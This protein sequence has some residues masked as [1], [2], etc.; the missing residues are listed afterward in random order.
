M[1]DDIFADRVAK[2]RQRFVSSL[3]EKIETTYAAIP[4]LGGT[5]PTAVAAAAEAYRCIHGIVG[6]GRTVGF[7]DIGTAA[8]NVE[9]VL[10][11]SYH[12]Q[13]G[14]TDDEISH[15]KTSLQ[16]LREVATRELQSNSPSH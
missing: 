15:L 16:T 9:D 8:H 5:E 1:T 13:R 6:I 11:P 4:V 14:L 2:V 7:P 10:R 12:A 3:G